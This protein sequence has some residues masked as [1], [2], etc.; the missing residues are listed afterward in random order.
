MLDSDILIEIKRDVPEAI[1]WLAAFTVKPP[2]C[3]FAAL[4]L[5]IGCQSLR[6]RREV[7]KFLGNF[8]CFANRNRASNGTRSYFGGKTFAWLRWLRR[9]DGSDSTGA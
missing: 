2:V 7:L 3:I 1:E 6:E 5:L 8:D 9:T 4:E